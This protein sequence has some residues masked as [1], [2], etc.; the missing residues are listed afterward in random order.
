ML[1]VVGRAVAAQSRTQP[2]AFLPSGDVFAPL[3]ADPKQPEFLAGVVRLN[4]N[5]RRTTVGAAAFGENIGVIRWTL[6]TNGAVQVGL[7]GG[8]FA[9]FDLAST[10]IDLLNADYLIGVPLTY[11]TGPLSLRL[12]VYHQSSHLGDEF[13]LQAAPTRVN[14]SFESLELIA[15]AEGGAARIYG[16]GEYIFRHEPSDLA[17]PAL[18]GGV[19]YRQPHPL[20]SVQTLGAARLA[21]G[22]DLKSW[23]QHDWSP[24][25]SIR[26]GLEFQPPTSSRRWSILLT[27]YAGASPYGQFYTE[28]IRYFGAGLHLAL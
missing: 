7:A 22:L 4:S 5:I 9:Q 21:A 6:R 11:R 23:K 17:S 3:L 28:E 12:R 18:H 24:A 25:V 14:L 15:S 8:V 27:W 2:V 26:L 19:E 10:S 1:I 16:G 20:F 13:M